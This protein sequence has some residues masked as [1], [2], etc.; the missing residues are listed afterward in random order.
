MG[1]T[2][3]FSFRPIMLLIKAMWKHT[4]AIE[5]QVYI[6]QVSLQLCCGD[7]CQMLTWFADSDMYSCYVSIFA[8]WEINERGFSNHHSWIGSIRR[9]CHYVTT[10]DIEQHRPPWRPVLWLSEWYTIM[11][12]VIW[13]IDTVFIWNRVIHRCRTSTKLQWF[14]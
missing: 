7:T 9:G 2:K 13:F 14:D 5:Y 10:S 6:W 4:Q 1:V 12:L 11:L 8:Y 3:L